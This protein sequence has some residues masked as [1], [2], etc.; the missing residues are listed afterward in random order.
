MGPIGD[1]VALTTV[2]A[3]EPGHAGARTGVEGLELRVLGGDGEE[4]ALHEREPAGVHRALLC[5]RDHRRVEQAA[6]ARAARGGRLVLLLLVFRVVVFRVFRVLIVLLGL[7]RRPALVPVLGCR[8]RRGRHRL[9][10]VVVGRGG[11]GEARRARGLGDGGLLWLLGVRVGLCVRGK[12]D[13]GAREEEKPKR[14]HARATPTCAP[15]PPRSSSCSPPRSTRPLRP[16]ARAS[17]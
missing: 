17:S 1:A 4:R 16:R 10:V 6:L 15:R 7:G 12:A 2:L 13:H 8:R 14:G 11:L 9:V 5:P 3:G